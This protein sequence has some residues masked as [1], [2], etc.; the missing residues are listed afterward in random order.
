MKELLLNTFRQGMRYQEDWHNEQIGEVEET[1]EMDFHE[2]YKNITTSGWL[3][4]LLPIIEEYRGGEI[5]PE[6]DENYAIEPLNGDEVDRLCEIIKAKINL[7][8]GNITEEEYENI[9]G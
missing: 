4:F 3:T 7:Q 1:T 8:E 5:S 2:Y 9:L 6:D